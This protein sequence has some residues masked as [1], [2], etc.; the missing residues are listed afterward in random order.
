MEE[1]S[2]AQMLAEVSKDMS[3]AEPSAPQASEAPAQQASPAQAESDAATQAA[4]ENYLGLD[5]YGKH[6]VEYK[7]N[8]RVVKE[9]LEVALNRSSQGYN[10]AQLISEFKQKEPTYQKTIEELNQKLS[11]LDKYRLFDEYAQKNPA[12]GKHVENMWA[13]KEQYS[14]AQLDPND[15][16]T[17]KLAALEQTLSSFS[18]QFGEKLT[19]YDSMVEAQENARDDA[20]FEKEVDSVKTAFK[21]FDFDAKDESGKSTRHYVMEHMVRSKIP[22]FRTAFLD[23]YH[24]QIL[25]TKE[26]ALRE[27]HAKEVQKRTK[28]GIID[29]SSTPANGKDK[30]APISN[31]GSLSYD[32]LTRM[33]L[34]D[35][36][37][38]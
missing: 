1:L 35:L 7:A 30:S 21:D 8:G 20:A 5:K 29:V 2:T 33:A 14:S 9:P 12:W 18:N 23:L 34:K 19:K 37:Y 24:D 13:N 3:P 6:L 16:V 36:G 26:Q 27:K 4:I 15:P 11:G 17:Q 38:S 25:A 10:Y 31:I 32:E 22:S 28:Q